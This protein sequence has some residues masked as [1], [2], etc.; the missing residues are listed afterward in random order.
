[1]P[2]RS[3]K[4]IAPMDASTGPFQ[5]CRVLRLCVLFLFFLHATVAGCLISGVIVFGCSVYCLD[6][7]RHL[8]CGIERS[9]AEYGFVAMLGCLYCM[10]LILKRRMLCGAVP[11]P[12]LWLH[13]NF[14]KPMF[15]RVM[16]EA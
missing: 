8:L 5:V 12:L 4:W 1:M 6:C 15:T 3:S 2:L 10:H 14:R 7:Y 11:A 13:M 9:A 16:F